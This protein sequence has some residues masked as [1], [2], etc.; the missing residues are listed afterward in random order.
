MRPCGFSASPAR[1]DFPSRRGASAA[2]GA[3]HLRAASREVCFPS[4]HSGRCCFE[5]KAPPSIPSRCG[6][7][8]PLRCW[9]RSRRPRCRAFRETF[10]SRADGLRDRCGCGS[11]VESLSC[12]ATYRTR[13]RRFRTAWPDG[14]FHPAA[15]LGFSPFA[16]FPVCGSRRH[17]GPSAHLPF[18]TRRLRCFS[19]RIR[20]CA[21]LSF[22]CSAKSKAR[23]AAP[24]HSRNRSRGSLASR[25][26]LPWASPLPG[27]PDTA[28]LFARAT[29]RSR[30]CVPKSATGLRSRLAVSWRSWAWRTFASAA[31]QRLKGSRCLAARERVAD[32][33]ERLPA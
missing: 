21:L 33:P 27:L 18:F 15:L 20:R 11:F 8:S 26:R 22:T 24:G 17:F 32:R 30:S 9:R 16:A 7:G 2:I 23:A 14:L 28:G 29:R 6:V 5:P 4:A 13:A 1:D 10:T 31:L 3:V 25:R 19:R 12:G